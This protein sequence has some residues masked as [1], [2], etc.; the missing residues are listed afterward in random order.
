MGVPAWSGQARDAM[1]PPLRLTA[2]ALV[3]AAAVWVPPALAQWGWRPR[4]RPPDIADPG[5][6]FC[7]LA[8]TSVRR[9]ASGSGWTTDYP[10]AD[11]NFMVRLSELTDAHVSMD[12]RGN[13]NHWVVRL[14]DDTLFDCPFIMASDIGTVGLSP[15]EVVRLRSYLLKGGLLWV[16]DFWGTRAWEHWTTEI[17]KVLPPAQYPILDVPLDHVI[18]RTLFQVAKVPQITNIGFWRRVDGTTTSER[19]SDS[20]QA[21]LRAIADAQGRIVIVMT[22]NTD[23]ADSWEREGEDPGFFHAFSPDGYALGINVVLYGMTH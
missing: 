8:Y 21:H 2:L 23:V 12:A 1:R 20:A 9:E 15:E 10:Y 16:D 6:S 18:F 5:F 19:G 17:A 3:M 13:P 7:R 11:I 14:T 4:F 22:H